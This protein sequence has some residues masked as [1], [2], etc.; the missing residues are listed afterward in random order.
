MDGGPPV[1]RRKI[2]N[3]AIWTAVVIALCVL[4]SP[5]PTVAAMTSASAFVFGFLPSLV[6][7]L[8]LLV[9]SSMSADAHGLRF[10]LGASTLDVPWGELS[11]ISYVRQGRTLRLTVLLRPGTAIRVPAPLRRRGAQDSREAEYL[12]ISWS[13]PEL[14]SRT[15]RL[16]ATLA[17]NAVHAYHP[18]AV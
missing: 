18:G 17:A 5:D 8:P 4:L 11:S 3:P 1:F 9:R 16:H 10:R 12:L 14:T 13:Q 2:R 6:K 15:T 7:S